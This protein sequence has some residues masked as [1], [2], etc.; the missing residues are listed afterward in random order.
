PLLVH[1]PP[2]SSFRPTEWLM[3]ERLDKIM[4][5]VPDGFLTAEELNL[6]VYIVDICQEAIA[7]TDAERGMFFCEYF[8]DYE[9]LVIKH[10]PWVRAPIPVPKAIE[11]KVR[12]M[13]KKQIE[14][15]KYEYLSVSYR[16]STFTMEKK[17]A[18]AT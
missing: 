7:W 6:M 4:N 18:V 17:M 3:Q 8:P 16:S 2:C 1:P 13:L 10:V 11:G 12:V 9:M 15:G 5:T 14:A